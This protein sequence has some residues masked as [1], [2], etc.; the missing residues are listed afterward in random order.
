MTVYRLADTLSQYGGVSR[1]VCRTG[2]NDG[3]EGITE[4]LDVRDVDGEIRG[5]TAA[6]EA[7]VLTGDEAVSMNLWGLRPQLFPALHAAYERF[8]TAHPLPSGFGEAAGPH[9]EFR[10]SDAMDE[11]VRGAESR[12]RVIRVK[13]EGFG[14]TYAE[15]VVHTRA[16][17]EAM[18][19]RGDYPA[20]L[21]E[22]GRIA[23]EA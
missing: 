8:Q 7:R 1:A 11:L 9:A 14:V 6:G 2:E 20:N 23:E 13:E 5:R 18:I 4:V 12:F 19:E 16:R 10:L 3:L 22:A 17:I 15:D 21:G